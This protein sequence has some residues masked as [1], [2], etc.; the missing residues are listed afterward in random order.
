[1]KNIKKRKYIYIKI[2]DNKF[3]KIKNLNKLK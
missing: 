1:M 2:K 3:K